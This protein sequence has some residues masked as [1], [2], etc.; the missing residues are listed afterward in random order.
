MPLRLRFTAPAIALALA[1]S[2]SL[3]AA[4]SGSA[5]STA[6]LTQERIDAASKAFTQYEAQYKSGRTAVETVYVWSARWYDAQ[7]GRKAGA[8]PANDHLKRMQ[9]LEA[10]VKTNQQAGMASGADAAAAAYYRAEA[11][12][13]AVE[14]R[15][16]KP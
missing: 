3:G 2:F 15:G 14:A 5:P 9:A 6:Q 10:T 4:W 16:G 13:W 8:G 12:L 11:D 1:A 7:G